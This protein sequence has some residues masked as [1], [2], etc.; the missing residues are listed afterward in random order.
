MKHYKTKIK[1]KQTKNNPPKQNKTPPKI[2]LGLFRVSL[3]LLGTGLPLSVV[4]TPSETL[5]EKTGFSFVSS[6]QLEIA[7]VLGMG[8]ASISSLGAGDAIWLRGL[9]VL[10]MLPQCL[11]PM[12]RRPAVS[13]RPCFL[14]AP[15]PHWLLESFSLLF[16]RT[17]CAPR[18]GILWRPPV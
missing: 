4:C 1:K 10:C 12:C 2:P 14:G 5:L 3:P 11:C 7:P 8:L 13:R 17:L 16:H 15:H 9:Q 6:Y 18:T